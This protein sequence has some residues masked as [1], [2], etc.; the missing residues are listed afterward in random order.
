MSAAGK[1]HM[2]RVAELGCILCRHL[3]YGQTPAEIH[4]LKE[5]CGAGQRHMARVDVMRKVAV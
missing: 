1:R 3:G 5:E 4:H 2:Q